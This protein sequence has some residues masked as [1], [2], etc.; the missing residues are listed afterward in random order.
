MIFTLLGTSFVFGKFGRFVPGWVYFYPVRVGL[1]WVGDMNFGG[2]VGCLLGYRGLPIIFIPLL[3]FGCERE[4]YAKSVEDC[5][6][7][8]GIFWLNRSLRDHII[9]YANREMLRNRCA[10]QPKMSS[11]AT[12]DLP[13]GTH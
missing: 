4:S 3:R 11:V 7:R 1:D 10:R 2:V 9:S 6:G 8:G 13:A 12:N 5:A